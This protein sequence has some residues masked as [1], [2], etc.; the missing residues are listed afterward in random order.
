M[1]SD[2]SKELQNLIDRSQGGDDSARNELVGRAYDRLRRLA[3]TMLHADFGRLED[4]HGT[5]TILNEAMVRLLP[6]LRQVRLPTVRDFFRFSAMQMRRALLDLAREYD[7]RESAGGARGAGGNEDMGTLSARDPSDHSHDP[8]KL[9]IWT[10]FHRKV[11]ELPAEER[12]VVDLHWY[13]GLSQAEVAVLMGIP[14]REV[15]RRWV[16][17]IRK[18]PEWVP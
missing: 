14:Q 2:Q 17:A 6:A 8:A 3:K 12:E 9:A 10:E 5:G 7:V 18:L 15:S 16:R 1:D 4:V 13:Q 11:E